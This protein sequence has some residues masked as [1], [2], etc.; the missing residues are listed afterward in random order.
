VD[1]NDNV[2]V[3]DFLNSNVQVFKWGVDVE[4]V[5]LP[6][7]RQILFNSNDVVDG[8]GPESG[9]ERHSHVAA[10]P[11]ID[12]IVR[13]LTPAERKEAYRQARML[14]EQGQAV[15]EAIDRAEK[16]GDEG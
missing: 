16:P 10:G 14:I 9:A 4:S 2:Y 12:E 6:A 8:P 11:T 7:F 13:H 1:S 5:E 3:C 15:Q